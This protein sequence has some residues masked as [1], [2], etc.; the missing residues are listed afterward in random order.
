MEPTFEESLNRLETIIGKLD[1]DNIS[2]DDALTDYEEAVKILKRCHEMLATA[3]RKIEILRLK[4]G[5]K[6]IETANESE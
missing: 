3:E 5:K 1:N 4:E 6:E 2:L